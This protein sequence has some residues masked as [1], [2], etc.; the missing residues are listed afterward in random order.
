M[1]SAT[2]KDWE[3]PED[4]ATSTPCHFIIK[5][6]YSVKYR[7]TVCYFEYVCMYVCM[8]VAMYATGSFKCEYIEVLDT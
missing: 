2:L 8:Y 3:W 7:S 6:L 4:E 1:L 5:K